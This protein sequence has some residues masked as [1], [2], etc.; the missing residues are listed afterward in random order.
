MSDDRRTP[1]I[2][3]VA[4]AAGVSIGTVSKALNGTGSLSQAT[5]DRVMTTIRALNFR[6]NLLAKSLHTGLSGS[7]GLISNDSFG[8]F[9]MPIMEGLERVL[10]EDGIGVFMANATDD[11]D[12]ERAHL[13]QLLAKQIDG[14]VV[15]SRRADRRPSIEIQG[16]PIPVIYVFSQG[17][18]DALTFLPDD[19]GGARLATEHLIA[20]GRRRIAHI[21]GPDNFEAVRLREIGWRAALSAAGL[22]P[23]A[24]LHGPW[25]EAWGREAMARLLQDPPDAIFC[26]NDQIARGVADTLR[27]AGLRCP[28]DVALVGFDNWDVMV[29]ACRPALTSVD[30]NLTALGAEAGRQ[31]SA[32]IKGARI[33]GTHRLPCT[34]I[35]RE[36]T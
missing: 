7:V 3:D 21:T 34:L 10:S 11:P 30:M 15:T 12:R 19:E 17:G 32:M 29:S 14:L 4:R 13:D 18:E 28:E 8:R 31:L 33:T 20:Q 5:R 23:Q 22:Q 25:S 6:P 2:H 36:S 35:H 27:E 1:T 16:L 26:G 9:T 24:L